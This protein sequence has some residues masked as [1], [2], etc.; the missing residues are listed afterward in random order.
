MCRMF[1]QDIDSA[2]PTI[3]DMAS[4]AVRVIPASDRGE[5]LKFLDS[6]LSGNYTKG[7]LKALWRRS[8][9]DVHF[10]MASRRACCSV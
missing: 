8:E 3:E 1:H 9:A 4:Y 10:A 2:Y 7:E 5:A 6:V